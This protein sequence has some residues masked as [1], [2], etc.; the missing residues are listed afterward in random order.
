MLIPAIAAG[1]LGLGESREVEIGDRLKRLG[2]G[3][4]AQAVG[5]RRKPIDIVGLQPQEF[6]CRVIPSLE[7]AAPVDRVAC[8][9]RDRVGLLQSPFAI[10][11]MSVFGPGNRVKESKGCPGRAK[12]AAFGTSGSVF[13]AAW[14]PF[15]R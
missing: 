12:G 1:R 8:R 14:V 11:L 10:D 4:S 2:H 6:V 3:G 13:A 5:Q 9:G 7:T 15:I